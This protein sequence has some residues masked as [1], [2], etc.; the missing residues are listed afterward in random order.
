M[1]ASGVMSD[2]GMSGL[3]FGAGGRGGYAFALLFNAWYLVL[4]VNAYRLSLVSICSSGS[5]FLTMDD[6]H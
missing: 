3:L 2:V 6:F 4:S 5:D 1:L